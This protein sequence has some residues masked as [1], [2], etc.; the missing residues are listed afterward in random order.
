MKTLE[1]LRAFYE[2]SLAGILADLD[3]QRKKIITNVL[4]WA[5]GAGALALA[6]ALVS[7][8]PG[9]VIYA[10]FAFFIV[11]SIVLH[12]TSREFTQEFKSK[13]IREIVRFI[14]PNLA[15][16]P[17]QYI[18]E[19][20][21]KASDIF[22]TTPDRYRGD[23]YIAGKIGSTQIEFSELHTEYKTQDSKGRTHWHTIFKGIFFIGDLNK[24]YHG[25]TVVLPDVAEKIFGFLGASLQSMNV[26]RGQLIKL[27]DPEFE[28]EFVVYGDDQIQSRYVLSTSLMKRILD[29][30]KKSRRNIHLAFINGKIFVAISQPKNLFEP[31]FLKTMVDFAPIQEYFENFSL[32]LGIVDDLNLNTRIWGKE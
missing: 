16:E 12:I 31:N 19:G 30:K 15:Y 25:R 11:Y 27:E 1:E 18:P 13:I 9:A 32:I 17:T 6:L 21:Y 22:K 5:I 4:V 26:T 7:S 10:P 29:F 2:T 20:I 23:D 14:D 8:N 28:K 3:V 24:E